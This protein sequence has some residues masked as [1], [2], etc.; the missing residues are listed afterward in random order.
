MNVDAALLADDETKQ[1]KIV[2]VCIYLYK[3]KYYTGKKAEIILD[4]HSAHTF[5]IQSGRCCNE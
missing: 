5:S 3:A 2:I 1:L 4:N